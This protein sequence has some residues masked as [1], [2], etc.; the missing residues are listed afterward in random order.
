MRAGY[1]KDTE[2]ACLLQELRTGRKSPL[3][4]PQ[5][6]GCFL[7]FAARTH[8]SAVFPRNID[9]VFLLQALVFSLPCLLAGIDVVWIFSACAVGTAAHAIRSRGSA[10][11]KASLVVFCCILAAVLAVSLAASL[12]GK[13]SAQFLIRGFLPVR[14]LF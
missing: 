10:P 11:H 4:P 9:S 13:E 1:T 14:Y 5:W 6:R 3:A 7:F 12:I 2:A 8:S